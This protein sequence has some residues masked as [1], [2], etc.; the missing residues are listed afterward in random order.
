MI[1]VREPD[2]A[3]FLKEKKEN[4]YMLYGL[5]QTTNSVSLSEMKF[6]EKCVLLL[7]K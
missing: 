1:E 6:S 4:G 7:G 5:E 3:A 2:I